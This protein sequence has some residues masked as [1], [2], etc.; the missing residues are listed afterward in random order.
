MTIAERI[1]KWLRGHKAAFCDDCIAEAVKLRRRQQGNRVTM[2]FG[3]CRKEFDRYD[4]RC[5]KCGADK[6]VIRAI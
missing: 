3:C 1:Y 2:A 5:F 6:L 4:G